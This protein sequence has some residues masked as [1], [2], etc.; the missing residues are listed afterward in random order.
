MS[1]TQRSVNVI[2]E[3]RNYL[4]AT[5]KNGV[6]LNVPE[7]QFSHAMDGLRYGM[8]N[9]LA[10]NRGY[11]PLEEIRIYQNRQRGDMFR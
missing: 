10:G 1:I 7:H 2:K 4:W 11:D 6:I 9:L 3:Y 5:D 8:S